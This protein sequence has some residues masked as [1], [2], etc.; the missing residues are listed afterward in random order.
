M[1]PPHRKEMLLTMADLAHPPR[2]NWR[3]AL[4]TPWTIVVAVPILTLLL[5][6]PQ[7]LPN[8]HFALAALGRTLPYIL[9]AVV[10]LAYLKA[11]GADRMISE[12]FKGRE[13]RMVVFAA[14]IG[15]LAPF[16]SCQVI[17]FIAALLALGTPLSAV[18]A[19]WLSSPLIDPP[20][21]MITAAALGWPF[22]IGKAVVA[23]ALGLAGGFIVMGVMRVGHFEVPLRKAPASGC[24]SAPKVPGGEVQ[25]RVW[26]TEAQRGMFRAE[27]LENALFL[28]KWLALAYTLEALLITYVPAAM[29]AGLV[30]GDGLV[31][32]VTA[33]FVGMPAYLNGY[34]APALLAGLM[35]Q[36]MSAG[37]AMAFLTAGAV[38][39]VPAMAAVW[40]LVKP[41]VFAVYLGLGLSGAIVGGV[42][43]QMLI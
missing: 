6:P 33:A 12:A 42:V 13:A 35:D 24:C 17:P 16:C 30:G 40:S 26:E 43:F 25:W 22:A 41:Q 36:G 19:F 39:S 11:A 14:L 10:M 7:M 31:P 32:I 27:F 18:M 38:S 29:I 15:G 5:D 28:L 1:R 34:V 9:I 20:T 4:W 2:I 37:A 8:L 21:L 23:V 3:A